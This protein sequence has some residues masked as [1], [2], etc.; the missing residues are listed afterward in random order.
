MT[1]DQVMQKAR[2][3][4]T[5]E[6]NRI[7]FGELTFNATVHKGDLRK[8]NFSSTEKVQYNPNEGPHHDTYRR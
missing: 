5:R 7:E 3:Y 4:I 6:A 8:L 2:E 1:V